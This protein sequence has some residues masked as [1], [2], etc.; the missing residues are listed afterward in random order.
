[1]EGKEIVVGIQ[2]MLRDGAAR[3]KAKHPSS[4]V[5]TIYIAKQTWGEKVIKK[6]SQLVHFYFCQRKVTT[7]RI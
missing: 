3:L 6:S 7:L 1:M 4:I 5:I 2:E